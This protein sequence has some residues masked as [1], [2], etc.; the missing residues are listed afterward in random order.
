MPRRTEL[1]TE[2]S[3]SLQGPWIWANP[4]HARGGGHLQGGT[5]N[6]RRAA[7]ATVPR[8]RRA[9]RAAA[10]NQPQWAQP[11]EHPGPGRRRRCRKWRILVTGLTADR[12]RAALE[13]A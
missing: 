13:G 10:S 2:G 12:S 4:D 7:V 3:G 6:R 9:G 11:L 8:L 1:C 5:E